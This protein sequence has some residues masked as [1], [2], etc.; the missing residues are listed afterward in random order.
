MQ[1]L[2]TVAFDISVIT[3]AL[4]VTISV[5]VTLLSIIQ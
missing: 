2:K 5:F 3:L 1:V 4:S